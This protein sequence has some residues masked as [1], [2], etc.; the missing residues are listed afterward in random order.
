MLVVR[1]LGG[2]TVTDDDVTMAAPRGRCAALLAWLALHPGMQPRGRVAARL[3]PDVM[4]ESARRSLRTAL[5]DLRAELGPHVAGHLLGTRDEIGLG[6]EVRVDV[7]DFADAAADGRLAEAFAIGAA[8]E[9]LPGLDHEWA[10][11]AR[12][13]HERRL[14]EIVERL[15]IDA[16]QRGD[17]GAAVEYT[18]RLVALDPLCEEH[19]RSLMR[20]LALTEDRAAALTVFEQHRERLRSD[21]RMAPSAA[22]RA[23][24]DEIR[25]GG[26]SAVTASAAARVATPARAERPSLPGPLALAA[27]AG[28]LVGREDE[29]AELEATWD[30]VADGHP[31]LCLVTGEAGI[32]KSRL[33]AELAQVVA[34]AG[35]PVLYGACVESPRPPYGPFVDAI[36]LDL[37]GLDPVAAG[38]RL[39]TVA[40]ELS[41]I[42]PALRDRFGTAAR[43]A[44]ESPAGEQMRL[45]GAVGDYLQHTAQP[46]ALVV[47][48]DIHW[49]ASGTLA[50][51][52][53][54]VRTA[55]GS[56]LLVVSS[57]D[58]PPDLTSAL[59]TFLS[60][61]G[62]HPAVRRIGLGGLTE[63]DVEALLRATAGRAALDVARTA[64]TLHGATGGSPLFLREVVRELPADGLLRTVPVSATV[65]D[66][67]ASRFERLSNADAAILDAAAVLGADFEA[68]VCALVIDQPMPDV[69]DALDRA[70]ALGIVVAVPG[71]AGR[72][73]FTHALLREVRYEAIPAGRRMR[74]HHAAGT[75]LRA[76]GAPVTDLA[77]HFC[78]AAALGDR[79]DA[80]SYARRAGELARERFAFADAAVYFEQAAQLAT[81]LPG[82]TDRDRCDLAIAHGEALHRAGDPGHQAVLLDAAETARRLDDIDLL[83]R[84]ALALSNQGWTI[85]GA[86]GNDVVQ[87]ARDALE[88]LPAGAAASRAR[89]MAMIAAAIL[90][91]GGNEQARQLGAEALAVARASGDG[92][93]LGEVLISAHWACLD[94]LNLDQRLDWA[95]EA[96]DLGER[97][98]N[99]VVLAQALRMLGQDHLESGDLSGAAAAFDRADRI[100]GELDIP[101]LRMFDPAGGATLAALAGRLD[102]AER[103][104]ADCCALAR[105]VGA[106]PPFFV[107]A[108]VTVLIERGQWEDGVA[109][110]KALAERAGW[111]PA[112]RAAVA[113]FHARLGEE[114][115]GRA[116]LRHF[117]EADFANLPRVIHWFP[118][119]VMLADA[120]TWLRD[121]GAAARIRELLEPVSGRTPW[122]AFTALWPIDIALAQLSV[123]LGEHAR[124]HEYLDAAERTCERNDL[125]AHRVRV[126]L[127]RAWA[128]RDAGE[129]VDAGAALA[130]AE[131]SPCPGIAREARLMG[132]AQ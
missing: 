94:P 105:R 14:A 115:E 45:F 66:H 35:A 111:I 74:L 38:R 43:V 107:G 67:V 89:L 20:R 91:A 118:G 9:L 83:A 82:L 7:R 58:V 96:S 10:Y 16:E 95:Q 117:T 47:I 41:R 92:N 71:A 51:L 81:R 63:P 131:T 34:A 28:P 21:L 78:A 99:P 104:G 100:A 33:I 25:D 46:L 80:Y 50:M 90:L 65:R 39:G 64:R 132:L 77:R 121:A 59:S 3:W 27:G 11:E 79:K 129:T 12:E 36:S 126:A 119:M 1:L 24:A 70:A 113:M 124:A 31:R 123:V 84:A 98:H 42:V 127:Y 103:L 110:L 40:G 49:A 76:A 108:G 97:L 87:V 52:A 19:A 128:L 122:N 56:I 114:D 30:A 4:D 13:E 72:F 15:A 55:A 101:F 2:L 109:S 48:E 75:V 57:R 68:R 53:H 22:T 8:G 85:M 32:G 102:E 86:R 61:L 18:R 125:V 6:P 62:R 130:A 73:A 29:L 116:H 26:G 5:L 106:H 17:P 23:L 112:F 120:A 93:V 69:L 88:R 44:G 60:D 54:I 37:R